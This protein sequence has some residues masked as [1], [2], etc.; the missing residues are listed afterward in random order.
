[1]SEIY[2]NVLNRTG[3]GGFE[4]LLKTSVKTHIHTGNSNLRAIVSGQ[5]L[6]N[7]S[8]FTCTKPTNLVGQKID[9]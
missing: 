5:Q 9:K 8:Y 4:I 1:M 2:D 7:N 3:K 6:S